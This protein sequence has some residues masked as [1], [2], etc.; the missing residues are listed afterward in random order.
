MSRFF[1]GQKLGCNK[2]VFYFENNCYVFKYFVNINKLLLINKLINNIKL[3]IL[4]SLIKIM[5]NKFLIGN[6]YFR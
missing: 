1:V 3:I 4:I 2:N 6:T 5:K